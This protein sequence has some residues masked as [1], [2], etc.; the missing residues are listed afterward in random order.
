MLDLNNLQQYRENNQIEAKEA[1]G[2]LP[3][4]LWE[5]YSGFANAEGG[6]I[7]LGVEEGPDKSLHALDLL[8]PQWIIED[9]WAILRDPA[10]VSV[11]LLTE[12]HVQVHTIDG[13]HIHA[14][15]LPT[16]SYKISHFLE[17]LK[18]NA[19][20]ERR[21]YDGIGYLCVSTE[22]IQTLPVA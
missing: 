13:K 20:S 6:V 18:I 19:S 7:L 8:D 5:T 2:G 4:S 11:N 1:L 15:H 17:V 10:Q 16:I 14:Q 12:D 22:P 3:E 21:Q 9:F